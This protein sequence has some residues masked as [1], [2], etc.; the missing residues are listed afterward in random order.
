M[1]Y[2]KSI[3]ALNPTDVFAEKNEELSDA[4]L[5]RRPVAHMVK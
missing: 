1:L 3:V 2:K 4:E 5:A